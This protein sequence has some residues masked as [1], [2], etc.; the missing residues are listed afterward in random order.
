MLVLVHCLCAQEAI[1]EVQWSPEHFAFPQLSAPTLIE[2]PAVESSGF[3]FPYFLYVPK[4]VPRGKPVRLL[5]EP[6]N[7]GQAT[8]DFEV[9]RASAK[10]L[11]SQGD[12]REL[13][14]RLHTPL[15]VP[16]FPR[17]RS[18]WKIYTHYL[19]R[20]TMLVR[21][22][23]LTRI[24]LQL[25]AMIRH[26][27]KILGDAGIETRSRVFMHG[28]SAS[29]G[30]VNRFAT[31]HPESVRA[32]AAGAINALPLYPIESYQG[33]KLNYP[34][35]V[36]DL[37][38]LTGSDFDAKAYSRVAQFLFMGF[39]DRNDTFPFSDAWD[40]DEREVIAKL[41]GKEMMPDRWE[42]AQQII[43]TLKIPVQ[44]VTYNGVA[45]RT[46]P[47]MWDDIYSFF[48]ANDGGEGLSK[49]VPHEYPFV[50]FR[51]LQVAHI[52]RIYWKGDPD[53]PQRYAKLPDECTF[54]MGIQDW[55]A[56][57]DYQQLRTLVEKAGFEF[58]LV[59]DG[60]E[61]VPIDRKAFCGSVSSGDG[62][63]QGFYVCLGTEA[64]RIVPGVEYSLRPKRTSDEYYWTVLP[65]VVLRRRRGR[66]SRT[67]TVNQNLSGRGEAGLRYQSPAHDSL[68]RR[69]LLPW[70][71]S[72]RSGNPRPSQQPLFSL[73][74]SDSALMSPSSASF[75]Q[76]C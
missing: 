47:E 58:E 22:G 67:R 60:R 13:A 70:A 66:R 18:Q 39:L 57:Q 7:T 71:F 64:D 76:Y 59:A 19:D 33:V 16:V 6:N 14:D 41:F 32:I 15:L 10:R 65:G 74:R 37:K 5:I 51:P 4:N 8:D 9:H 24:D 1:H 20:D 62:T 28:F 36:A 27:R 34:L 48:Q 26:A 21:D 73:S 68:E 53:L 55:M 29:A 11:A 3:F 43:S 30:F 17:P 49:I 2:T 63:F 45:H 38:S 12:V 50:P 46:L 31:L 23:Q 72:A 52:N 56:G 44:T 75:T 42:R 35:G 40:D 54:V 25:L 69:I 61:A